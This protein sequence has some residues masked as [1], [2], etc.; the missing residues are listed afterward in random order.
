MVKHF[1]LLLIF[2]MTLCIYAGNPEGNGSF[3]LWKGNSPD[4]FSV[5]TVYKNWKM[6]KRTGG[7]YDG[8]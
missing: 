2:S 5:N 4:G 8:S 6:E 1:I 7:S 3:E